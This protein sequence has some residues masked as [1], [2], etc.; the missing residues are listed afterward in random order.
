MPPPDR[1]IRAK[2]QMLDNSRWVS[3]V[4]LMA[5]IEYRT[6]LV[7][8]GAGF[9]GKHL[10]RALGAH[11]YKNVFCPSST[12]YDLKEQAQVR[13]LLQ[14]CPADLIIHL[15]A[16]V[17]GIGANKENPGRFLYDNLIMGTMLMEEA[18]LAA[19]KKFVTIGTI[20]SYPKFTPVPFR[21]DDLWSGYPEETNA[22]YGL[23]KKILLV[24]GQAYR[25]QYGF[26]AIYLM[27][28]NLYGPGDNFAP[29]SSHVI[30]ALISRC[31][32]AV[33]HKDKEIVLWG[34]GTPTRE[35]LFVEDAARAILLAAERY[36]EPAPVNI[37]SGMEISIR[38]LAQLIAHLTDFHGEIIWDKTKPNG[39]PRRRLDIERAKTCFGFEAATGF[40]DGLKRTIDWYRASR[41]ERKAIKNVH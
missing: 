26:N 21:E 24:Q 11:G 7:T 6:T 18:R 1:G 25:E 8:G 34:D 30:P 41:V 17:G 36:N 27:P 38:D 16:V 35:F 4:L 12:E 39:Q 23:A 22:P 13:R 31:L 10:V 20:C 32:E 14:D 29:D 15:A 19:V 9:L 2:D 33:E 40:E 37:G 5:A 28:V 3:K